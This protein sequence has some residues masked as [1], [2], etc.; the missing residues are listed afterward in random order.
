MPARPM[1]ATPTPTHSHPRLRQIPLGNHRREL[2]PCPSPGSLANSAQG[3]GEGGGGRRGWFRRGRVDEGGTRR[4]AVA[5]WAQRSRFSLGGISRRPRRRPMAAREWPA[6]GARRCAGSTLAPRRQGRSAP[7]PIAAQA[8][9]L[10]IRW[11][12]APA[13]RFP[14]SPRRAFRRTK[15]QP[16]D[17]ER[18]V[19]GPPPARSETVAD[20]RRRS[21][22][23][24]GRFPGSFRNRRLAEGA[25]PRKICS[26]GT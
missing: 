12:R 10:Q 1:L 19:V 26:N 2:R 11:A 4:S 17:A 9:P 22:T 14:A 6:P 7:R 24:R 16:A 3:R 18:G 15:A 25:G 13:R 8:G 23:G 20:M 5:A 21:I